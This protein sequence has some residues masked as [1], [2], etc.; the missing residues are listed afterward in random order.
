MRLCSGGFLAVLG[1]VLGL[2]GVQNDRIPSLSLCRILK[3]AQ[4]A[5][6][7]ASCLMVLCNLDD[8][9]WELAQEMI[10]S[11][12]P[13][14]DP[15]VLEERVRS[16]LYSEVLSSGVFWV[17]YLLYSLISIHS[18]LSF[19]KRGVNADQQ[20]LILTIPPDADML[21]ISRPQ[22]HADN[23]ASPLLHGQH[24]EIPVSAQ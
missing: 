13:D 4:L 11:D 2:I 17:L 10:D 19:I 12:H 14:I 21:A 6:I 18:L 15:G 5:M 3:L 7:I 16:S 24:A 20:Q 9:S 22:I 8:I 23:Y 1:G